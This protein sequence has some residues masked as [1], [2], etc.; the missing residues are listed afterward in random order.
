MGEFTGIG[1]HAATG[2]ERQ[3]IAERTLNDMMTL[4]A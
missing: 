1:A 2:R 4:L 3:T